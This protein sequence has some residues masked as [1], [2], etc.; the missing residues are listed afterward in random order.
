MAYALDSFKKPGSEVNVLKREIR[1]LL[2]DDHLV[3]REGTRELLE[4]E[5]DIKVVAEASDGDE[6]IRLAEEVCPD[7]CIMDV[8]MPG[9]NGIDATRVI[10][11]RCPDTSILVFSAYDDDQ[12]ISA[13][14]EAGASGYLLK[15]VRGAELVQAV[16]SVFQGEAVLHPSIA[17]KVIG[18]LS[19][20][21]AS[22]PE[23]TDSL[24]DRELEVLKLVARGMS[25]KEIG[26]ELFISPRTVQVHLANIFAKLDAS[27]RTE[28]VF[29]AIKRGLIEVDENGF[30]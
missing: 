5:G 24:S 22:A 18:K 11:Q 28:A 6:A 23:A 16:R 19:K 1:V 7:V 10:K 17:R 15:N 13:L 9:T 14:L 3:V 12:Y 29:R 2:A 27:S 25:N 30:S 21:P 20:K 8:A 4:R 26:R